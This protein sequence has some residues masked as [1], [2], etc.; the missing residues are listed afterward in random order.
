MQNKNEL[1]PIDSDDTIGQVALPFN[2]DQFKD[3]IVSLLGN[4]NKLNS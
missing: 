4:N 3:F 1:L 2:E